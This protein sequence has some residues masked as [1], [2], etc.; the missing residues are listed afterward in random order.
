MRMWALKKLIQAYKK[1]TVTVKNLHCNR[2]NSVPDSV[3]D[4]GSVSIFEKKFDMFCCTKECVY[5]S[6]L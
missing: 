3:I 1:P 6:D 5:L 2:W 4:S